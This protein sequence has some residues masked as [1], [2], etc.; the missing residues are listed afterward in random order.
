MTHL[1]QRLSALID[2]ELQDSERVTVAW[3]LNSCRS[4]RD[5]VAALHALKNRI[6]ATFAETAA[7]AGLNVR[8]LGEL[9][10][11]MIRSCAPDVP[12]GENP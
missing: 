1:G 9:S 7:S 12:P 2:G 11:H 8:E 4:C 6:N 5:E 3:H 10:R